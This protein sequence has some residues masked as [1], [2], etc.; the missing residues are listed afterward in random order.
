MNGTYHHDTLEGST[1]M[2]NRAIKTRQDEDDGPS[3]QQ[4]DSAPTILPKEITINLFGT[5]A[6]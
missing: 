5:A 6:E 2:V 1:V 3:S 4:C